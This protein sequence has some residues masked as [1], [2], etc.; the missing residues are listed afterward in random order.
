MSPGPCC[1][2]LSARRLGQKEDADRLWKQALSN[3][4]GMTDR[5]RYRLMGVYYRQVTRNYDQAI[6]TYDALLKQYPADGHGLNNLANVYFDK[7]NFRQALDL[8]QRLLKIYPTSQLYRGNN[9][10]YAMYAGDFDTASSVA[11]K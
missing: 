4:E 2:A 1:W 7:L 3:L 5:E 11:Q 9:A 6:D 10:L 8:N